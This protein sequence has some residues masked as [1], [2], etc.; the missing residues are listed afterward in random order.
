LIFLCR[1][2]GSPEN[3][4]RQMRELPAGSSRQATE[5]TEAA[6]IGQLEGLVAEYLRLM[7]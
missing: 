6:A 2:F 4:I 5:M 3:V 7:V 1:A